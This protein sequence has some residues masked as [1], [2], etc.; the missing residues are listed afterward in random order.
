M[1][2]S[3]LKEFVFCLVVVKQY[4]EYIGVMDIMNQKKVTYQFDHRSRIKYYL[5]VVFDIIDIAINNAAIVYNKI[6][7]DHPDEQLDM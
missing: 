1:K 4:N 5:R 6:K 7:K 2:K 3:S